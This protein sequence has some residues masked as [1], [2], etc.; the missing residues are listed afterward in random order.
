M[1]GVPAPGSGP[2]NG[3]DIADT[4][5]NKFGRSAEKGAGYSSDVSIS[6][7]EYE[8]MKENGHSESVRE[9]DMEYGRGDDATY[10]KE[11]FLNVP[12]DASNEQVNKM[13]ED[14][15]NAPKDQ[16]TQTVSDDHG[17]GFGGGGGKEPGE[18]KN[19]SQKP[20]GPKKKE[21]AAPEPKAAPS[22][23]E[24]TNDA[25]RKAISGA[26]VGAYDAGVAATKAPGQ[27]IRG[28]GKLMPGKKG[29]EPGANS[30]APSS[31]APISM[32]GMSGTTG[33]GGGGGGKPNEKQMDAAAKLGK[34]GL[35][36][37]EAVPVAM[38][39]EK[40]KPM[41]KS[42]NKDDKEENKSSF[43]MGM[44]H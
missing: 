3:E 9:V 38:A 35:L 1:D 37:P 10:G 13:K 4:V 16:N 11:Y 19:T 43:G 32:G 41:M 29:S 33:G 7:S 2:R 20:S 28:I 44:G 24:A 22:G 25:I 8:H 39:Y 21:A 31:P 5:G 34:T 6:Q 18:E 40:M 14:L 15:D 12:D 26:M 27:L 42:A 23:D 30:P 36:G 17:K